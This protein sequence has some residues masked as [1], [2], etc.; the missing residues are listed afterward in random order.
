[1]FNVGQI[2][3]AKL[4]MIYDKLTVPAHLLLSEPD[5]DQ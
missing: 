1:V 2:K 4:K 5:D 3:S